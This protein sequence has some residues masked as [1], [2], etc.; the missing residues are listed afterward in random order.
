M[1]E[2]ALMDTIRAQLDVLRADSVAP[3]CITPGGYGETFAR[4][5]LGIHTARMVQCSNFLGDTLDYA[6]RLGFEGVLLV[7]HIGKWIK[8]A[9]G[10]FQTHSHVAD[11]RME[12]LAAHAALGG[13]QQEQIA[14]IMRCVT[15]DEALDLLA[16]IGLLAPTIQSVLEK[17]RVHI[18]QRLESTPF[19][20]VL[21]SNQRGILG[22]TGEAERLKKYF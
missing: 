6:A 10:I 12:I 18:A 21:F 17:I 7:G 11:A 4:E 19:G 5:A 2:A 1:S 9:G 13:A 22:M 8:V 16:E 14:K 3:L 20:V 15:T